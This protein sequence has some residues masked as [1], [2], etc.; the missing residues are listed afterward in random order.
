MTTQGGETKDL[1]LEKPDLERIASIHVTEGEIVQ[2]DEAEI[3]L[4]EHGYDWHRV[5]ALMQDEAKM[6]KLIRRVDMIIL[7]LLCGT[8]MLQY[9]DKTTMSYGAVFDLMEETGITGDEYSWTASLFYFGY[10][11]WEYPASYLAQHYKTGKVVAITILAW[12]SIL[13]ITAA[14]R[15]FGGLAVCRFLLGCF[16]APITPCFMLIVSMWYGRQD[17]PLRAGCFYSCNGLGSCLGGIFSY[18]IG[19]IDG[20]PVYKGIFLICGGITFLWGLI[21]LYFLPDSPMTAKYFTL[22]EKTVLLGIGRRNQTGLLNHTIKWNQIKEGFMDLQV[23]ILFIFVLLN[24]LVNGGVANFGKL[25]IKGLVKDPLQTTALGIPQ[26]GFQILFIVSGGFIAT[27]FKNSRT[28]VMVMYLFPT[29]IGA[30]LL[31]RLD[32]DNKIGLLFGYYIIGSFVSS[33]TIALQMP[34]GNVGGYTKRVTATAFVFLGYCLGNII[35]PHAFLDSEAP[36]YRTGIKMIL[37]C[38]VSQVALAIA[39]RYLLIRRNSERDKIAA[40]RS[41][42]DQGEDE[43]MMDKTDFENPAFRY[44]L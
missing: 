20:F 30:C 13:M 3:F 24:E 41:E 31:W 25:I 14:V 33:L 42:D 22:E 26:G 12:A 28:I 40:D 6:K 11:F 10:L 29:I 15:T 18:A 35:G 21:I 8:Y 34:A 1:A 27:K 2:L 38:A 36:I 37:G 9:I 39:L 44:Q 16:E 19:Q 7:P 23:W 4:R 32:R 17:Q 5:E 43:P